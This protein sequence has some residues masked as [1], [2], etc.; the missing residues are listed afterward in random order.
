MKS[1]V[2]AF[3][4]IFVFSIS[5]VAEKG[6]QKGTVEYIRV[7][8]GQQYS[9][10]EPP[11]Y[12][13]TLNGVSSAGS[14]KNYN[15]NALFIADNSTSLSMVLAAYASGKEIAVGYDDTKI[16]NGFCRAGFITMGNPPT[17]DG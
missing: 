10:W 5:V 1:N 17:L 4:S 14:C 3:L 16:T 15:G 9:G 8:D 11:I 6:V 2:S 12:W 13:F 7:H